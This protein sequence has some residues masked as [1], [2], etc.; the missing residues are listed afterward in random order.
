[1]ALHIK[2]ILTPRRLDKIAQDFESENYH[3]E[4]AMV[5]PLLEA[6]AEMEAILRV[7]AEN[8]GLGDTQD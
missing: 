7:Y 1:M 3:S 4:S 5:M 6:A 8:Q 2:S